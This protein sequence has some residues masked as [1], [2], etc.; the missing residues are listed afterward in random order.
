MKKTITISQVSVK[1]WDEEEHPRHPAGTSEGGQFAPKDEVAP[2]SESSDNL[3]LLT[4]AQRDRIEYLR[5]R[6]A[7]RDGYEFKE[8]KVEVKVTESFLHPERPY[9]RAFLTLNTGLIGDEGTMAEW[10]ARTRRFF[11]VGPRGG[12]KT[13][14]GNRWVSGATWDSVKAY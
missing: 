1:A 4:S 13:W 8:N 3:D 14:N 6:Y 11:V 2:T 5:R 7:P 10:H 12:V 9:I